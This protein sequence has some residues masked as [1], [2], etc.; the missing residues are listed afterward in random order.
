MINIFKRVKQNLISENNFTKYLVYALGEIIL[1]V[2]GILIALAIDNGNE[3][4]I[5]DKNEQI[6]L[7]G[8]EQ[9]FQTSKFKLTELM[10]VNRGNYVGAKKI[11]ENMAEKDDPP[12]ESAFSKLLYRTFSTDIAF[13]PNNSLLYEMI[14]SGNLKNLSNIELRKQLTNWISTM[15]DISRQEEELG[16][17]REKVLD[18]F[19]TNGYSLRTIFEQTGVY[20]D[21]GLAKTQNDISN[22][23]LL[24]STEFENNLLMFILTSYATEKAHYDPLMQDLDIILDLIREELK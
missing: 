15:A 16:I 8:L 19:R 12:S 22:L 5:E 4:R 17:Q 21:L 14:N 1:V 11:L 7:L 13:N 3:N 18:I 24:N 2:I 6:Y 10:A 23:D 9:E 20:D